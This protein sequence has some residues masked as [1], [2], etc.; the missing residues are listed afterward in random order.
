ML[1][2]FK[3]NSLYL[4]VYSSIESAAHLEMASMLKL[5]WT[6][7]KPGAGKLRKRYLNQYLSETN[8]SASSLC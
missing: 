1:M 2:K 6:S 8:S 7:W 3:L 4:T 5:G